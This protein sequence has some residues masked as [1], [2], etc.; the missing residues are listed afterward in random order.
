MFI[1]LL[2]IQGC[3]KGTQG[4]LLSRVLKVPH[5]STGEMLR[6]LALRKNDEG[7][8]LK[9]KLEH[10]DLLS[11]DEMTAILE[12]HLPAACI[13]DG[14]PRTL[15]QAELLDTIETV[16]HVIHIELHEEEAMRRALARGRADDTPEAIH[17]RMQ[18]YH[19]QADAII[20]YYRVRRKLIT[21]N[22]DQGV[23]AV[24]AEIARKLHLPAVHVSSPSHHGK[25]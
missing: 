2:G 25:Q 22:G 10:G 8:A 1:V 12:H 13:L 5:V 3:G 7:R 24:F 16:D 19:A 14:Y 21:V 6:T 15:R 11:D 18:Q 20:D 9:A 4:Q 23:D 17:R